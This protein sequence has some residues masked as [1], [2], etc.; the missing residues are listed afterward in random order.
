MPAA[1]P[2]LKIA[3]LGGG[4]F[5]APMIYAGLL[6][7]PHLAIDEVTLHDLDAGRLQ[8][9]AA[10]MAGM[11]EERARRIPIRTTTRI[12]DALEGAA[13]VLCAIRVGGMEGRARDERLAQDASLLGQETV[14][15]A[16]ILYALRTVP[17]MTEIATLAARAAPT[18]WFLN[19]TNPAGVVTE[20]VQRVLGERAIGVCDSPSALCDRVGAALGHDPA[21]LRFAYAGLN[22][23]G[24]LTAVRD[25]AGADLLPALLDAP[26]RLLG[27]EEGRLFGPEWLR[28]IGAIPNE[29]LFYYRRTR[30][31]I[32]TV[33]ATGTTRG[34]TILAQQ[35]AFYEAPPLPPRQALERWRRVRSERERTYLQE[36]GEGVHDAPGGDEGG[37]ADIALQAMDALSGAHPATLIANVANHGALPYLPDD[38]VVEVPCHVSPAGVR[39]LVPPPLPAHA[40]AMVETIKDVEGA[41]L[42]ASLHGSRDALLRAFALHPLGGGLDTARELAAAAGARARAGTAR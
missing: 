17:V 22:H 24:W 41:I 37:Y 36:A 1:G 27:T 34:E 29:Y 30:T 42:D 16:G 2:P 18:A 32:E 31:A 5:R 21:D 38:A 14:G 3:L 9:V 6:R 25:T 40:R 12:E 20:A 4:G 11:A 35:R 23:L 28:A 15:A 26:D 7:R 19:F 39:P 8:R 10:V 33:G 13:F